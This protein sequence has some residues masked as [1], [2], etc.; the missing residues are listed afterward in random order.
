MVKKN[1][2]FLKIL[3]ILNLFFTHF[4][5]C[6]LRWATSFSSKKLRKTQILGFKICSI[7][8]SII[9]MFQKRP[10]ILKCLQLSCY[11]VSLWCVFFIRKKGP[12]SWSV[13]E[14]RG[15]STNYVV[16]KYNQINSTW[17]Q[18]F[19]ALCVNQTCVFIFLYPGYILLVYLFTYFWMAN[20]KNKIRNK[21]INAR[22]QYSYLY[23]KNC[24]LRTK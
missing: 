21:R 18:T 24:S 22:N 8:F 10:R 19:V 9:K 15:L 11:L 14:Y 13:V 20:K 1:E 3:K 17:K 23:Q 16:L 7:N 2:K 6:S 12:L 5:L 4:Q